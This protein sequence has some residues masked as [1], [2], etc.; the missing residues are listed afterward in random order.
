MTQTQSRE[1]IIERLIDQ[2]RKLSEILNKIDPFMQKLI[3]VHYVDH[4]QSLSDI[5]H[6][7][8]LIKSVLISHM[9]YEEREIYYD[10]EDQLTISIDR[11]KKDH[12]TLRQLLLTLR[13]QSENFTMPEDGCSTYKHTFGL[14]KSLYLWVISHLDQEEQHLYS[15]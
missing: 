7:F 12:E 8:L 4:G 11:G 9:A 15:K 3:Y 13:D 6:S 5:Y 10:W 1:A 2:H 14:L